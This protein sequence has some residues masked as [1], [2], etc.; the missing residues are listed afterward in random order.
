MP[1]LYGQT[2]LV[3]YKSVIKASIPG[4]FP[5]VGIVHFTGPAPV[6]G[7]Q[8]HRAGLAA[9][10][11]LATCQVNGAKVMA[12]ITNGYHLR[13]RGRV[14]G[15]GNAVA[16]TPHYFV[17]LYHYT[18]KRAANIITHTFNTNTH[19]LAHK[20]F[21]PRHTCKIG[22]NSC[23][24]LA[25]PCTPYAASFSLAYSLQ[26]SFAYLGANYPFM[27]KSIPAKAVLNQLKTDLI[28]KDSYRG[29]TL[30]YAWMA[31]QFG[32]FS[33]GFIPTIIMYT[34]LSPYFNHAGTAIW[35]AVGVSANWLAFEAINFLGPLMLKKRTRSKL[36]YVPKEQYVFEPAWQ[37][38]AFDT[39]TDLLFFWLGAFCASALCHVTPFTTATIPVLLVALVSPSRY[40]YI[41][42]MYLQMAEYPYQ[43]RLSQWDAIDMPGEY[44]NTIHRFLN[45]K[46]KGMHLLLFGNEGCGK[47]SLSIGIATEMAI[48]HKTCVYT[49]GIKL[50]S[51]FFEENE[52]GL[53][54]GNL[55]RWCNTSLLVID[56]VNSG[57]PIDDI[58]TAER[59]LSYVDTHTNCNERN[60]R[61][62]SQTN[63]IWVMGDYIPAKGTIDQWKNMLQHIGV[64]PGKIHEINLLR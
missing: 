50:Y 38:L 49:T 13:M 32:H 36:F 59:F 16:A 48:Q 33:L 9:G 31:N 8:A 57:H 53:E 58:V 1:F 18:T 11:H 37:N 20:I 43:L 41:T 4:V 17:T 30:T 10:I 7:A 34:L 44:R 21:F 52:Q 6:N 47:T 61:I 3:I 25:A 51:L 22:K 14:V 23:K 12:S 63:V 42:K 39:L 55:W 27:P 28:G 64:A 54:P 2:N 35:C 56:D 5:C 45:S 46:E 26:P 19:S 15:A 40:W 62:I 29:V 24:P 60:R